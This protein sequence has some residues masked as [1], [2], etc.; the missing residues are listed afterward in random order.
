MLEQVYCQS[1]TDTYMKEM[2]DIN[3][4]TGGLLSATIIETM[5]N[6]AFE[7]KQM[8]KGST[9]SSIHRVECE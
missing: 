1:F 8:V 6:I 7:I 5:S 9:S 3:G 2:Y 4:F